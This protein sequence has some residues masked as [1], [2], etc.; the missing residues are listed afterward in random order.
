MNI[1]YVLIEGE[2]FTELTIEEMEEVGRRLEVLVRGRSQASAAKRK[3][4]RKEGREEGRK[5][6]RDERSDSKSNIQHAYTNMLSPRFRSSPPF[7][8]P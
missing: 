3:Y 2:E 6:G 8:D 1:E 5:G 4:G 7:P